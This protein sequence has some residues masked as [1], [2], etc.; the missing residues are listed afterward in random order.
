MLSTTQQQNTAIPGEDAL[1]GVSASSPTLHVDPDPD[2]SMCCGIN[3]WIMSHS[4][5][6]FSLCGQKRKNAAEKILA[7][8]PRLRAGP[9]WQASKNLMP[10]WKRQTA[11]FQHA[12]S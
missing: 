1:L 12:L 9:A 4:P 8:L 3:C 7:T 5:V 10:G 6:L 11:G 2:N